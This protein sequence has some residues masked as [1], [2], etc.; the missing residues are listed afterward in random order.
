MIQIEPGKNGK[1][2]ARRGG[3]KISG[4]LE[5]RNYPARATVHK[6]D[7]GLNLRHAP[8][9]AQRGARTGG[10]GVTVFSPEPAR[11]PPRRFSHCHRPQGE[12][13]SPRDGL[14]PRKNLC[15]FACC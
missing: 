7:T 1:P 12:G 14:R 8:S 15:A 4:T 10:G 5:A 13:E 6:P 11:L 2:G 3:L 9:P